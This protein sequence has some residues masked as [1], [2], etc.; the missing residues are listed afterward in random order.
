MSKREIK[1]SKI[2]V[3]KKFDSFAEAEKNREYDKK[4]LS[5]IDKILEF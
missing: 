1:M 2:D 5:K 3:N 4:R